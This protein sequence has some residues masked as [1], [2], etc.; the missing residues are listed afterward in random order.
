MNRKLFRACA[1]LSD[2][3]RNLERG[4]FF[5]SIHKT[6]EHILICDERF[7]AGF[8]G[9]IKQPE[10]EIG[11]YD[12]F[13]EL[14][15]QRKS[16]DQQIMAWAHAVSADWL[17]TPSSYTH[18]EDGGL[19]VVNRGFW[20]AHMFNHQTHHRGQ[21]TTLLSQLGL[22]IGSTDLHGSVPNSGI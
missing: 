8:T 11:S 13:D 18:N 16:V 2:H 4:A 3:E 5:G 7:I 21:I 22:D 14:V 20:V 1:T 10:T 15:R 9:I 6:L 17:N 19:R 12:S